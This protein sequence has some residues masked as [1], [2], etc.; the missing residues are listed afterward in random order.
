LGLPK[1]TSR[2]T[3]PAYLDPSDVGSIVQSIRDAL[4]QPRA[5]ALDSARDL[6]WQAVLSPLKDL[7]DCL[8]TK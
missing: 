6:T 8:L 2:G 4:A 1:N 3:L 7:Y 5:A